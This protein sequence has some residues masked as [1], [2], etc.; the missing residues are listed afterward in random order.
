[1]FKLVISSDFFI[2]DILSVDFYLIRYLKEERKDGG[3]WEAGIFIENF[4]GRGG[5][6]K[7]S[8]H[9]KLN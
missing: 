3:K 2:S 8:L 6:G 1:M 9:W 5:G 7:R 4:P